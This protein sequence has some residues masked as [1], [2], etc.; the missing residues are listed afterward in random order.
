MIIENIEKDKINNPEYHGKRNYDYN[1]ESAFYYTKCNGK[2]KLINKNII[3]TIFKECESSLMIKLSKRKYVVVNS[4]YEHFNRLMDIFDEII[5]SFEYE[6]KYNSKD[7]FGI[8]LSFLNNS[9]WEPTTRKIKRKIL[10]ATPL[11]PMDLRKEI[12][13]YI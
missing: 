10:L 1:F 7:R 2:F 8:Q 9:N 3:L 4:C 13:T 5:E 6:E 12:F 11:V